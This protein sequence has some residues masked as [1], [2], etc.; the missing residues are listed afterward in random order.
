MVFVGQ[1]EIKLPMYEK[2]IKKNKCIRINGML[3]NEL[4]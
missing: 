2:V 1:Y 3:E 4:V